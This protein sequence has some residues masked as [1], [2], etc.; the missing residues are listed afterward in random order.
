MIPRSLRH[1][2]EKAAKALVTVQKHV[3]QADCTVDPVKGDNGHLQ[4]DFVQGSISPD[5]FNKL[6]KELESKGYSFTKKKMPWIG[7]MSFKGYAED[8]TTIVLTLPTSIDRLVVN[9]TTPSEPHSF[10]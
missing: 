1:R 3:P 5:E 2:L 7:Q 4:L 10:S 6:G 9:D 8:K